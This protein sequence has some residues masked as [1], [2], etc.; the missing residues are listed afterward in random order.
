M[1]T[2]RIRKQIEWHFYNYRADM[3]AYSDRE[4]DVIEKSLTANYSGR[5]V[6]CGVG[7]PTESK[8]LKL[9]EF[10]GDRTWASVVR[11]TF[12]AFRFEPEYDIM[13]ALY[14]DGIPYKKL[15]DYGSAMEKAFWRGRDKWL[16]TA[17]EWAQAYGLMR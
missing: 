10:D 12:I 15:F 8:A 1:L 4:R 2:R 9:L 16:E 11:N 7:N 14:I 6:S 5:G 17:Y 3:A 13:Q